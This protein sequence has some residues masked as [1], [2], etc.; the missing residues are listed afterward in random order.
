MEGKIESAGQ[1]ERVG[2]EE[3]GNLVVLL[4]LSARQAGGAP[5]A[6]SELGGHAAPLWRQE[7]EDGIFQRTP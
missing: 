2:Y 7:E 6:S 1:V 4:L 3:Q 5:W